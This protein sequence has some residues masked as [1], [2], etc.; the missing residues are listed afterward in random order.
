MDTLAD[1]FVGRHQLSQV[2]HAVRAQ[3]VL[4]SPRSPSAGPIA[5]LILHRLAQHQTA[6]AQDKSPVAD[7]GRCHVALGQE[8]AALAVGDP[9][10]I[11][12]FLRFAAALARSINGCATFSFSACGSS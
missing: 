12:S 3:L 10:S 5:V 2:A 1:F 7:L 11:P 9:A 6:V 4:C 8:I